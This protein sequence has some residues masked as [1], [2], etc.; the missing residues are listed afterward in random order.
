MRDGPVFLPPADWRPW[1]QHARWLPER[2]LRVGKQPRLEACR[3]G[4]AVR[5]AGRD[6]GMLPEPVHGADSRAAAAGEEA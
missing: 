1:L 4:T 6:D 2:N 5:D 3:V